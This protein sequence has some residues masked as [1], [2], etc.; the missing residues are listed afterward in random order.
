MRLLLAATAN[1]D[2]FSSQNGLTILAISL[3]QKQW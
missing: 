1:I 2:A 3:E